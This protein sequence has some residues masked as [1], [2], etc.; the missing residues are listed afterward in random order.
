ML[1]ISS[2][3]LAGNRINLLQ[4]GTQYFPAL[5]TAI[6]S[7]QHEVYLQTYIFEDDETGQRIASTLGRAARRGVAVRLMVDG[8]GGG[9]FVRSL[10]STLEA[11]GVQILVYRREIARLSLKRH[12]LRRMH[13]KVAV[14]DARIGF[15]GGINIIDD[16]DTPGQTPPRFDYAVSVEG[17]LIRDIHGSCRH[18]WE[19]VRWATLGRRLPVSR[20]PR[21]VTEPVGN[22][23]ARFVIRDNVRHR[24]DIEAAYLSAIEAARQEVLIANAYFLPGRRFRHALLSAAARGVKVTVLLQGRVEYALLHYATRALY[25]SLLDGGVRI[26]E[27]H[28][29]FLHAKVAVIDRLWATVGSSNIDPFSLLLAREANVV[30]HD[31]T[32]SDD[33][34]GS[35]ERAIETGGQELL[36]DAWHRQPRLLRL[37]SWLA[38]GIVRMIMGLSGQLRQH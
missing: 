13:R 21:I 36:R 31:R 8:F 27:Y 33:L 22:V 15:V 7:A 23:R 30:I 20:T 18:L 4:N 19:L 35:L 26:V 12:R 32:F 17:P 25:G 6:E 11:D 28:R 24:R 16:M 2:E 34:R 5:C 9:T 37:A 1:G 38:Y 29:S 10:M 14:I 3:F